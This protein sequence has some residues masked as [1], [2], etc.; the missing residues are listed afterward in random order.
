MA[1]LTIYATPVDLLALISCASQDFS[2]ALSKT[3]EGQCPPQLENSSYQS[4]LQNQTRT[5]IAEI[6]PIIFRLISS[7]QIT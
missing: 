1:L 3:G 2:F 6:E 5:A 4:C 7:E